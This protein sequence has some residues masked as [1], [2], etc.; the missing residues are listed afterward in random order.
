MVTRIKKI[1]SKIDNTREHVENLIA[2]G[3]KKIRNNK[4]VDKVEVVIS[5]SVMTAIEV[6][7]GIAIPKNVRDEINTGVINGCNSINDIVVKQLEK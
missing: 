2:K 5:N 3:L 7:F 1:V 4:S 6:K